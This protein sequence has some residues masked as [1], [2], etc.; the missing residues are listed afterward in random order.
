MQVTHI[1]TY[2]WIIKLPVNFLLLYLLWQQQPTAHI[3]ITTRMT[4]T[5]PATPAAITNVGLCRN[6]SSSPPVDPLLLGPVASINLIISIILPLQ[7]KGGYMS[8]PGWGYLIEFL[9]RALKFTWPF[10]PT[11][12]GNY[13][14]L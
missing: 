12:H 5:A 7:Y 9:W 8:Q 4:I 1:S 6:S 2:R 10:T 14:I 11:D 3:T 13:T